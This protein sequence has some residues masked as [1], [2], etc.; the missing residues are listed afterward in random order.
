MPDVPRYSPVVVP[1]MDMF[2]HPP[3][4]S[5]FTPDFYIK[6]GRFEMIATRTYAKD[7]AV[8]VVYGSGTTTSEGH[9]TETGSGSTSN[10]VHHY[11]FWNHRNTKT[12]QNEQQEQEDQNQDEEV[13]YVRV[14][15]TYVLQHDQSGC[16]GATETGVV[17]QVRRDL[18]VLNSTMHSYPLTSFCCSGAAPCSMRCTWTR[19]I[20]FESQPWMGPCTR[21]I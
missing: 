6:H 12:P 15:L 19:S 4:V 8:Y 3:A 18:E 5:P 9:L 17:E 7:E 13:E 10:F 1:I 2:N 14:S 20:K 21:W 16:G 11:N